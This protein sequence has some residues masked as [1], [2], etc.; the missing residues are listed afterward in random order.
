VTRRTEPH[1]M[2]EVLAEKNA[3]ILSMADQIVA[4]GQR[5]DQLTSDLTRAEQLIERIRLQLTGIKDAPF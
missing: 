1:D 2:D 3:T 5:V 4:L